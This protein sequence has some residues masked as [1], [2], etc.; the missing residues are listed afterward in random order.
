MNKEI[1]E[2]LDVLRSDF[3]NA[4]PKIRTY[5]AERSLHITEA[6]INKSPHI[7]EI[8][9]QEYQNILGAAANIA[10]EQADSLELAQRRLTLKAIELGIAALLNL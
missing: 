1:Q 9:K 4:D 2:I 8:V 6:M 7:A 5:I 10:I 3:K